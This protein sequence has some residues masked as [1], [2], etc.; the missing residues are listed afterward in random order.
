MDRVAGELSLEEH[1]MPTIHV[2]VVTSLGPQEVIRRLSDFGPN[3][4]ESWP[5]VHPDR[6][7]VHQQGPDWADV[8]EGNRF[9]WERERYEWDT[10]AGTVSSV[11][12][13]SNV[14][15]AGPAWSYRL[16]P[17]PDGTR[18]DVTARRR[19]K[20]LR[21]KIVGALLSIIGKRMIRSS[22]ASALKP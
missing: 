10:E 16:I 12:T 14:W 15:Q 19:G 13:D 2:S 17:Q 4:A 8:T 5:N 1:T 3:R 20:G 21:G 18:V 11:T 6:V 22:T 7:K 9:A